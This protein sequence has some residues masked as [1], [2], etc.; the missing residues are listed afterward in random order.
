M[1]PETTQ[2]ERDLQKM[3]EE[4]NNR[5]IYSSL[6]PDTLASIPDDKLEQAIV[7]YVSTKIRDDWDNMRQIIDG[8]PPAFRGFYATWM[9]EADVSNGGFN[10]YFWNPYGYWAEDAIAAFYEYGA[11]EHAEVSKK[12][13][14]MFLADQ[15]THREFRELGT[16]E[17]F[18][19]S[20]KH[21]DLGDV[22]DEFYG[23]RSDLSAMRIRYVRGNP[24]KFI[25]E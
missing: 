14:A 22:D 3:M 21:T 19:E 20:Y 7:D 11:D 4:F 17:A 24:E 15:D 25:G 9:L 8:L 13:V 18:S 5:T 10:Q 6:D 1:D 16:L 23:I 12:A 2:F